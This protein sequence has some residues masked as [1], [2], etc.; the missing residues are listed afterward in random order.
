MG[1]WFN[2][3]TKNPYGNPVYRIPKKETSNKKIIDVWAHDEPGTNFSIAKGE[4]GT[5][6][7][8]WFAKTKS[9]YPDDHSKLGR[10][11]KT[12]KEAVAWAMTLRP[13]LININWTTWDEKYDDN[14][15]MK[16]Y[17]L[18]NGRYKQIGI[19]AA[20]DYEYPNLGKGKR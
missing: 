18:V 12:W 1:F 13:T 15:H 9:G 3:N 20:W 14:D 6:P 7:K 11:F 5:E 16:A 10:P 19:N 17:K 4:S 8:Q 2:G